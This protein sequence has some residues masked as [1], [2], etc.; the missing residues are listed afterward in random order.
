MAPCARAARDRPRIL[1]RSI[2]NAEQRHLA[3]LRRDL[4]DQLKLRVDDLHDARLGLPEHAQKVLAT[5]SDVVKHLEPR[6]EQGDHP[7]CTAELVAQ[8]PDCG[9]GGRLVKLRAEGAAAAA[10]A[11]LLRGSSLL[12]QVLQQRLPQLL[13]NLQR[14]LRVEDRRRARLADRG[15]PRRQPLLKLIRLAPQ[16]LLP[17]LPL[18]QIQLQHLHLL[19]RQWCR[20]LLLELRL[21]L[22]LLLQ[23]LHL[24]L[25]LLRPLL[26]H[27]HLV[28]PPLDLHLVLL[29]LA[30]Q[31]LLVLYA[32]LLGVQ[33]A[34]QL[35]FHLFDLLAQ[36][37]CR[38]L[39]FAQPLAGVRGEDNHAGANGGVLLDL[40]G[41]PDLV[42]EHL[43]SERL[44]HEV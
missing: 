44:G 12:G 20:L 35:P 27:I 13:L 29:P 3:G 28:L 41:H 1:S 19:L 15:R 39:R 25:Q 7:P 14:C 26:L 37:L 17:L 16:R 40:Q 22:Q 4:F 11:M 43:G 18:L 24:L 34:R 36:L 10:V 38:P 42:P 23:K 6:V 31:L 21:S 30:L 32:A 9:L 33:A 5:P 8:L 2:A